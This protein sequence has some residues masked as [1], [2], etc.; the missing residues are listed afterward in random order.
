[1]PSSEFKT[2]NLVWGAA[3]IAMPYWAEGTHIHDAFHLLKEYGAGIDTAQVYQG[4]E[5]RLGEVK[6]ATQY[7]LSIDTKWSVG[8]KFGE[9]P[10][11]SRAGMLAAAKESLARLAMQQ[12]DIFYIHAYDHTVPLEDMVAGVNDA[13]EAGLFRR[14]GLSNFPADVVRRVHD[15]CKA[16]GYVLPTVFQGN[17][18]AV[19]RRQEDE[20]FPV[21]RELGIAFYAYS[22]I[23][24]GFLTKT[25]AKIEA[26]GTRFDADQ[27]MGIYHKLYNRDSFLDILDEWHVIAQREG[28]SPAELAYRWIAFNSALDPKHGD[29]VV[30][31]AQSVEQL[32]GTL[33]FLTGGP[34]SPEAVRDIDGIW[35]KVKHDAW[36]DNLEAFHAR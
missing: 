2:V 9:G 16:N 21:L 26:G 24:G 4:S 1:M 28:V 31:G 36:L 22:P 23:A 8:F 19:A 27:I 34:L 18:S 32:E 5:A 29:G 10:G 3:V 30:F 33:K 17:Y 15:I 35:Q 25:R 7:G 6:A 12:V 14:F 20:L 13:Y 11:T